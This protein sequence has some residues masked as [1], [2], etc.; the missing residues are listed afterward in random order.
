MVKRIDLKQ[1]E[2]N[3]LRDFFQ[4]GL[5][6]ILFGACF[7]FLGLLLPQH[8]GLVVFPILLLVFSAPLTMGLKKRFTY[9]RTGYVAFR[10]GDPGPVPWF[11]LGSL[12]LGLVTLVAVLIAA[13]VLADPGQWYRW[14]PISFGIWLAGMFLGLG[15]QVRLVRYYVVAGVAPAGGPLAA[16]LPLSGKLSNLGLFFAV[17]GGVSLAW[18][19]FAFALFLRRNLCWLLSSSTQVQRAEIAEMRYHAVQSTIQ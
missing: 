4:D 1:V 9:P 10:Q 11:V 2:R 12:V 17:V 15:L 18:G 7:L 16:L 14:F 19:V 8:G 13:G 3:L 5:T 6:D